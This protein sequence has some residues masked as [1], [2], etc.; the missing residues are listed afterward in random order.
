MATKSIEPD[1]KHVRAQRHE[2]SA[3]ELSAMKEADLSAR[4]LGLELQIAKRAD[5]LARTWPVKGGLNLGCWLHAEQEVL[6]AAGLLPVSTAAFPPS[7][8]EEKFRRA[9]M[10]SA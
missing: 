8:T 10:A 2:T 4:L 5:D 6:H 9:H 3:A 1:R 7:S